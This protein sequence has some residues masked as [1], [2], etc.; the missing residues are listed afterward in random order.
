MRRQIFVKNPKSTVPREPTDGQHDEA[1]NQYLQIFRKHVII[2]VYAD[3][4]SKIHLT[5]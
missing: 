4:F 2:T 5:P 3:I 1:N